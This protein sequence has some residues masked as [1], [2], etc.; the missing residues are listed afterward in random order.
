VDKQHFLRRATEPIE[1]QLAALSL[2]ASANYLLEADIGPLPES[3]PGRWIRSSRGS[4]QPQLLLYGAAVENLLKAVRVA[5]G[6]P[7]I[8]GRSL[9]PHLATHELRRYA[10]EAGLKLTKAES[11][12]L[13]Q[14]QDVVEAGKYPVAKRPGQNAAAWSFD[15]PDDIAAIWTLLER[16]DEALRATGTGCAA[17]T[18][19]RTL[20][21]RQS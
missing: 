8:L 1:W 12:V 17:P 6:V 10:T 7:A 21:R 19:L 9:N 4:V 11:K 16:L 20:T 13:R 15:Y 5:Q 2:L 3:F 18:N 14:L